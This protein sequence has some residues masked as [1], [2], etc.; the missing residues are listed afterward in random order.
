MLNATANGL[1]HLVRVP[2]KDEVSSAFTLEEVASIVHESRREG[3]LED[4]DGLLDGALVFGSRV[5]GDVMVGLDQLV[6]VRLG[7]T[8][9]QVE[10]LVV[11]T[12]Y[13]RYPVV[14]PGDG[15]DLEVLG[16]LH[17]KDLLYA[18]DHRFTQPVPEKRIRGLVS[19]PENE[20]VEDAL[21]AMRRSGS[22]LARVVST[23]GRTIGVLFL[24]DVVEELVGEVVDATQRSGDIASPATTRDQQHAG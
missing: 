3:L 10:E 5:A 15:P 13:S 6:T 7:A 21:T 1:L 22:H 12:G 4:D 8:P 23:G 24:E 11:R 17:V 18:D 20:E 16:Y 9:E 19:V 14:A 2:V